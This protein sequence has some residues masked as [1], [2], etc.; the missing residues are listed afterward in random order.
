M[1]GTVNVS[2]RT[3]IGAA[4][5]GAA[6]AT[7]GLACSSDDDATGTSAGTGAGPTTSVDLP[8]A[9]TPV[10]FS[11]VGAETAP[12]ECSDG[13]W[14]V[15]YE[16][17]L[18]NSKPAPASLDRIEVVDAHDLGTVVA[19]LADDDLTSS[20]H[21]LSGAPE[22]ST[23]I[24]PDAARLLY[25]ELVFDALD[26]VPDV[27]AHRFVGDA[28]ANPGTSEASPVEYVT[29]PFALRNRSEAIIA[30]PLRGGRWL[31]VNGLDSTT[32]V[33]RGSVQSVGGQLFDAQRFAIDWMKLDD[34]G[35][36]ASG[37]PA[38]LSAYHG[39][40]EPVLAV[41][42]GTVV[43]VADALDDQPPG[44]LPDPADIT[45]ETV[46]GNHVVLEIGEDVYAFYAHLSPGSV[47]VAEGDRV[48]AGDEIGE[49]G[50]SGNTSAPHLH[51]HLMTTPDPLASDSI[52]YVFESFS[53]RGKVSDEAWGLADDISGP[54]E[55]EDPGESER[56]DQLPLGLDVIS[57]P[58]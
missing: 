49:L 27:V 52:P 20:L 57:F 40:G 22:P 56:S 15:L 44:T 11:T 48:S 6:A 45:L 10:L 3:F 14:R 32:G 42:D 41:A 2:R 4:A 1:T 55:I 5:A 17:V 13:R 25:V 37:D 34:A 47:A 38:E 18:T 53:L 33:H 28:A 21:R 46:D 43:D 29:A 39:Y 12:V 26:D 36:L 58:S 19:T 35:H 16:L 23:T 50:N 51:L 8:V 31:A 9:F 24:A 54:W 30:A 7:T